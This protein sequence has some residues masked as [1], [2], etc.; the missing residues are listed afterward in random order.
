MDLTICAH[1]ILLCQDPDSG[2]LDPKFCQMKAHVRFSCPLPTKVPAM[3]LLWMYHQRIKVGE[4]YAMKMGSNYQKETQRQIKG[5]K[6]K[7]AEIE[8]EQKRLRNQE[9]E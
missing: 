6:R 4:I 8:S 7:T 2:C 9:E 5:N 1:T 3:E